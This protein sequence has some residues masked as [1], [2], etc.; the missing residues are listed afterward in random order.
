VHG[1]ERTSNQVILRLLI[2]GNTVVRN[3]KLRQKQQ[4]N[5]TLLQETKRLLF[6]EQPLFQQKTNKN[7]IIMQNLCTTKFDDDFREIGKEENNPE[8]IGEYKR[9]PQMMP[10]VGNKFDD[11]THK[12]I[13]LV[14]ESHYLPDCAEEDFRTPDGWYYQADG[15]LDPESVSW[16]DTREVAGIGPKVWAKGHALY[17]EVNKVIGN[18]TGQNPQTENLFQYVAYYNYFLRP[19]YPK[20]ESFKNICVEQDLRVAFNAFREIVQILK[21]DCVYFFSKF[22]WESLHRNALNFNKIEMDYSPHPACSWW[23]R[24]SY[25]SQG[26]TGKEKFEQFLIKNQVF[27]VL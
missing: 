4:V 7:R 12:K 27:S 8:E 24:A 26:L 23:N 2:A 13:L 22:G 10:W 1:V 11:G 19:A 25:H 18:L 15:E 16:T 17:K 9:Y 20:G 14:G 3:A 6:F 5:S 21:P